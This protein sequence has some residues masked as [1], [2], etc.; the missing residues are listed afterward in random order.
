MVARPFSEMH[1]MTHSHICPLISHRGGLRSG[2][3]LDR[4]SALLALGC[5]TLL[6]GGAACRLSDAQAEVGPSSS[7]V[8]PPSSPGAAEPA[9]A[10]RARPV[11]EGAAIKVASVDKARY[12]WLTDS[13]EAQP[14]MTTLEARFAAPQGFERVAQP[15]GSF[16]AWLRGLPV[17][18]DRRVVHSHRGA[19]LNSPSAAVVL[20]DVGERDL[21]Q[22]ADTAIRLHAEYLWSAGRADNVAYHF[23]SGDL[24]TWKAWRQGERFKIRGNSVTRVRSGRPARDHGAFRVYLDNIFRYAGTRSLWRDSRAVKAAEALAPGDFFVQPGGP[25]H[26]VIVLDVAA[27]Q[28][29]RRAALIGQGFMPAQELH[30]VTRRGADVLDG[31]W[32]VLPGEGGALDTPSWRPFE[33]KEARRFSTP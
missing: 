13:D 10:P 31:V 1:A 25:G 7:S 22:C 3:G 32:F 19:A 6:V 4:R 8:Q 11:N 16:G 9:V 17:R 21:Q 5:V 2:V 23:T 33:R 28:D 24:S 27:S 18:L 15:E 29:G 20:L 30:V 14:E 12:G 26:A